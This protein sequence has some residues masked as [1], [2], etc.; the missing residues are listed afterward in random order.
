MTSWHHGIAPDS[1]Q[2][3]EEDVRQAITGADLGDCMVALPGQLF[4][5]V[6]ISVCLWFLARDEPATSGHKSGEKLRELTS[7]YFGQSEQ[8]RQ[9]HPAPDRWTTLTLNFMPRQE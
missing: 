7:G 3:G 4:Y 5:S 8:W 9:R 6:Q 1:N 2:S